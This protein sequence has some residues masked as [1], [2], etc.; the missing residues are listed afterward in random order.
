MEHD[1]AIVPSD[2]G[3][4]LTGVFV[5]EAPSYAR[6]AQEFADRLEA[7]LRQQRIEDFVYAATEEGG[8]LVVRVIAAAATPGGKP[9]AASSVTSFRQELVAGKLQL[10]RVSLPGGGHRSEFDLP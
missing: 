3:I 8:Q 5:R 10:D 2:K 4:L 6:E 1:M 9:V 7:L